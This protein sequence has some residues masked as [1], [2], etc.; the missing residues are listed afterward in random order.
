MAE[1]FEVVVVE[2]AGALVGLGEFL[3][4]GWGEAFPGF[5]MGDA[6][7]ELVE[8]DAEGFFDVGDVEFG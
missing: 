8:A 5:E 7:V 6:G 1:G 2:L 3:L 4:L